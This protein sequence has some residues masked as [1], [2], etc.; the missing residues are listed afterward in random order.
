M[1]AKEKVQNLK[2]VFKRVKAT[3]RDSRYTQGYF[4]A[5]VTKRHRNEAGPFPHLCMEPRPALATEST[6]LAAAGDSSIGTDSGVLLGTVNSEVTLDKG[7]N[8]Y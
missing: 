3:L 5:S 6:A 8:Y 2:R 4:R 7:E 1:W